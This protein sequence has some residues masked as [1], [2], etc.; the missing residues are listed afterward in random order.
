M[1]SP[2]DLIPD[3]LPVIG[4]LDDAV[5]VYVVLRSVARSAGDDAL[6]RHWRGSSDGLR[7]VERFLG[8]PP[9]PGP[10]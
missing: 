10:A 9:R 4:L 2:I 6:T 3:L 7:V 5:L 1:A 8:L